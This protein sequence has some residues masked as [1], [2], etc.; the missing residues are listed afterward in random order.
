MLTIRVFAKLDPFVKIV[1][2]DT[3]LDC[4]TPE[5]PT[6]SLTPGGSDSTTRLTS[7][8]KQIS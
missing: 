2:L 4:L 8:I 7:G 1:Y 6:L 3:M 5:H